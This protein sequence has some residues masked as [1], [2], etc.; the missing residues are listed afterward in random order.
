MPR[1]GG[2]PNE[3]DTNKEAIERY[4]HRSDTTRCL[5]YQTRVDQSFRVIR[6][7]RRHFG[8]NVNELEGTLHLTITESKSLD[9]FGYSRYHDVELCNRNESL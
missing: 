3:C 6:N 7:F 5:L 9:G 1:I 4:E 2:Q 8:T